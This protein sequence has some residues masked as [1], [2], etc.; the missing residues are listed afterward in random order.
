M[1][2]L[3]PCACPGWI[4]IRLCG[5]NYEGWDVC[6]GWDCWG[7]CA[8]IGLDDPCGAV[9]TGK[10]PDFCV[11]AANPSLAELLGAPGAPS[12]AEPHLEQRF[13][14]T[15]RVFLLHPCSSPAPPASLKPLL[16]SPIP[17]RGDINPPQHILLLLPVQG[18]KKEEMEMKRKRWE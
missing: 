12:C 2:G 11:S 18:K 15:S 4:R 5:V 8:G 14:K 17:A 3:E 13:P 16:L 1:F 6:T 9:P 7:S 10:F